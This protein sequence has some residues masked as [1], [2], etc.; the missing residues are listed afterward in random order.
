[1]VEKPDVFICKECGHRFQKGKFVSIVEDG[2]SFTRP[3][4]PECGNIDLEISSWKMAH[5]S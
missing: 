1:M 2:I 5:Q 4:C 3:S